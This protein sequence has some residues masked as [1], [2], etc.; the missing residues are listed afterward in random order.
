M[1]S[2][3]RSFLSPYPCVSVCPPGHHLSPS[4][5]KHTG[6]VVSSGPNGQAG[7]WTGRGSEYTQVCGNPW[8]PCQTDQGVGKLPEAPLESPSQHSGWA[9]V[10]LL[11]FGT[12]ASE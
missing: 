11:L 6:A 10:S 7:M 1:I 12:R 3:S 2:E 5:Q 8:R 9:G 4:C